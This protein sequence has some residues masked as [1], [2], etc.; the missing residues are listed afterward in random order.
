MKRVLFWVIAVVIIIGLYQVKTS[1]IDS[2][3]KYNSAVAL[4][5]QERYQEALP[6]LET[7]DTN[8]IRVMDAM[9]YCYYQLGDERSI[10]I[11]KRI[12]SI[13]PNNQSAKERLD[14][15]Q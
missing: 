1:S 5:D 7:L 12:L 2:V 3:E 15:T 4:M 6:I 8:E 10:E 13:D 11:D 9:A 14:R